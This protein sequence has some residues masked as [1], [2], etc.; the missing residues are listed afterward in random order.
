MA[1]ETI[2]LAEEN[3]AVILNVSGEKLVG[4][5]LETKPI[6]L[7]ASNLPPEANLRIALRPRDARQLAQALNRAAKRC[8]RSRT[9]H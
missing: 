2:E 5:L 1:D 4:L 7:D 3:E 8:L 9:L 6:D